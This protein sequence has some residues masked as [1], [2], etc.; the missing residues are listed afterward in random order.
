MLEVIGFMYRGLNYGTIGSGLWS[1]STA[2]WAILG[3][4]IVYV[5]RFAD[6]N[7]TVLGVSLLRL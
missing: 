1:A 4:C 2:R 5:R 7:P 3:A 6:V